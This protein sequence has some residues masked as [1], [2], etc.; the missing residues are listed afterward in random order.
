MSWPLARSS[1]VV[2]K[3]LRKKLDINKASIRLIIIQ[4][5][6]DSQKCNMLLI[7][8]KTISVK[9]SQFAKLF[10]VAGGEWKTPL[11]VLR[12]RWRIDANVASA[13]LHIPN[14]PHIRSLASVHLYMHA[15]QNTIQVCKLHQGIHRGHYTE[16]IKLLS[17][18]IQSFLEPSWNY[19]KLVPVYY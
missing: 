10:C 13:F 5:S 1:C 18:K 3:E 11:A 15:F 6:T 12:L 4:V 8:V 16:L 17:Y 2:G 14:A 19:L 9:L 7:V